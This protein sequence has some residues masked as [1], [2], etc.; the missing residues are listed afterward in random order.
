M[1]ST[2]STSEILVVLQPDEAVPDHLGVHGQLVHSASSR[3]FVLE[4]GPGEQATDLMDEPAVRWAGERPPDDVAHE[5]DEAERLFVDG[6]LLRRRGKPARPGEGL[7]WD[8]EG[9]H[10][11]DAPIPPPDE[12]R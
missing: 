12:A 3:L 10:P 11:P 8:A 2:E 5:L 9:R 7:D 1:P 4:L 6:W